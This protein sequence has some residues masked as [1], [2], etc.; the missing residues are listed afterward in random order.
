[1]GEHTAA[2]AILA[3]VVAICTPL[4]ATLALD[5]AKRLANRLP[6]TRAAVTYPAGLSA[7]EVEVL[8][9][10]A[11]GFNNPEIA[12]QLFLS[13]RTIEQHLRSIYN[14]LGVSS[15]AAASRWA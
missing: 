15:R 4:G 5:R 7:R 14:K 6:G 3:A 10:V 8:R 13:R 11:E 1:L 2:Q 12:E 9:L